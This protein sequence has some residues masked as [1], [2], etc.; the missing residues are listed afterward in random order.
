MCVFH[1]SCHHPGTFQLKHRLI[2]IRLLFTFNFLLNS[3]ASSDV[4]TV[5]SVQ[6]TVPSPRSRQVSGL[7]LQ[8][9][10][11][12]QA[13]GPRADPLPT[14]IPCLVL[15]GPP[16]PQSSCFRLCLTRPPPQEHPKSAPTPGAHQGPG[17]PAPGLAPT[18]H[19][20]PRS[21]RGGSWTGCLGSSCGFH[22]RL[23]LAQGL[24]GR[25]PGVMLHSVLS[26]VIVPRGWHQKGWPV[27]PVQ[28]VV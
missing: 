26:K 4:S 24:R 23:L 19:F 6:Q 28:L 16:L 11:A 21:G 1:L 27:H 3:D 25:T 9:T 10:K 8:H 7:P 18:P 15:R 14:A 5:H 2:E 12:G 20:S 13:P 17:G 22:P